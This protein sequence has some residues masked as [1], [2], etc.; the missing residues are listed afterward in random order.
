M[1][2]PAPAS[3]R[4]SPPNP[5]PTL[6]PLPPPLLPPPQGSL[7]IDRMEAEVLESVRPDLQRMRD[8][9]LQQYPDQEHAIEALC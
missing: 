2:A 8:Q 7:F 5:P 3:S 9:Y 4:S 1:H 6:P